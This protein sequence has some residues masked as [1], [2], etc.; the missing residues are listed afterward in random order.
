VETRGPAGQ[1]WTDLAL[2]AATVLA[3]LALVLLPL[4]PGDDLMA[5][6]LQWRSQLAVV[7]LVPEGIVLVLVVS[8]L[9]LLRALVTRADATPG[10]V[11]QAR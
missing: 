9:R 11:D 1:D 5:R 4:L 7:L 3:V 6:S 2:V 10:P 8:W